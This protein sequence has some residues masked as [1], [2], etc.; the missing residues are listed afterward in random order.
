[1]NSLEVCSRKRE[2]SS[3]I[4]LPVSHG[5]TG[6]GNRNGIRSIGHMGGD[7][8]EDRSAFVNC[9]GRTLPSSEQQLLLFVGQQSEV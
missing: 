9:K 7:V 1:M 2:C 4:E 6:T 8:I 5:T 3:S